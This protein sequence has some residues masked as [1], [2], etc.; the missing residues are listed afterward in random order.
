MSLVFQRG[1]TLLLD[2]GSVSRRFLV[3]S[4]SLSQTYLEERRSIRTIHNNTQIEDTNTNSK[5]EVSIE[6][7]VNLTSNDG[8]LF[9]WFGMPEATSKK[10]SIIPNQSL[11]SGFDLYLES[12]G[13]TY[14]VTKVYPKNLSMKMDKEGPLRLAISATG[15]NW[16]Q[17]LTSPTPLTSQ[18]S[19]NF[20]IG[21]LSGISLAGISLELSRSVSWI[22][23][24]SVHDAVSGNIYTNKKMYSENYSVSG[25]I[26]KY[27]RDDS[28]SHSLNGIVDFIYGDAMSVHLEPCKTL[29]RWSTDEVHRKMTDYMLLPTSTNSFIQFI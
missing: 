19:D 3:S 21:S 22:N 7:E 2:N 4:A 29:D 15:A 26:T 6:F 8:L 25:T 27:K 17:V 1:S 23:S 9:E 24:K 5:G 18:T 13:A 20:I 16:E 10:Y 28:L 11:P 12:N 14:K